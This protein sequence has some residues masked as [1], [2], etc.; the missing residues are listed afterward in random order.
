M[1]YQDCAKLT[2]WAAQEANLPKLSYVNDENA[3]R[4]AF[5]G[6]ACAVEKSAEAMRKFAEDTERLKNLLAERL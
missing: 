4:W 2:C 3:F 6:D 5:N 1:K